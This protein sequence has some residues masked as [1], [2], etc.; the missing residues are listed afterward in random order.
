[1]SW[2]EELATLL[3]RRT[4]LRLGETLDASPLARLIAESAARRRVSERD[5]LR[6][7]A[8]LPLGDAELD[9]ILDLATNHQTY[10]FRH[11]KQLDAIVAFAAALAGAGRYPLRI[12]CAG[13]ATG[14]EPY[15]L[16]VLLHEAGIDAQILATDLSAASLAHAESGI[17]SAW[18]LRHA[19]PHHLASA[20]VESS[21]GWT[22]AR[23]FRERVEFRRHNLLSALVPT[24]K[25]GDGQWDIVLCRN[26]L[27]HIVEP[28]LVEVARRLARAVASDGA[29]Y[30]SPA[31]TL[32]EGVLCVREGC[33][34]EA[35]AFASL[36]TLATEVGFFSEHVSPRPAPENDHPGA[37]PDAVD[38]VASLDLGHSFLRLHELDQAVA[39]YERASRDPAHVAEASFFLGV[40]RLKRAED[41]LALES[42]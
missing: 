3:V 4:G 11:R 27:I 22:L 31:E 37:A 40:A 21:A 28:H 15:G 13:C 9:A 12:W 29:L 14:E 26:V 35:R 2:R 17:Y 19:S 1:M 10:F 20:F 30:L 6:S 33:G 34:P 41:D 16:A 36:S 42:L 7:L 8:A 5:Y 39:A 18:S 23:P 24:S 25:R 32:P 38:P